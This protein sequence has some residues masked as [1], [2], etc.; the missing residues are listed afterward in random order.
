MGV[1][2]PSSLVSVN[3][4]AC[5]PLSLPPSVRPILRIGIAKHIL[6]WVKLSGFVQSDY[7]GLNTGN[8]EKQAT[9]KQSQA[10]QAA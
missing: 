2:L 1:L 10:R 3:V 8:G 7:V 6:D 4:N 5:R 9:A